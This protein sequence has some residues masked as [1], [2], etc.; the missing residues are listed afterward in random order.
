VF[1]DTAV[2][3]RHVGVVNNSLGTGATS[4]LGFNVTAGAKQIGTLTGTGSTA[5]LAGASLTTDHVRQAALAVE[6]TVTIR[7]N[8]GN[9]G[10]SR[11]ASLHVGAAGKLDLADN[12]LIYEYDGVSPESAVRSLVVSGRTSGF[13][14]LST[15]GDPDDDKVLAVADNAAW[16]KSEFGGQSI[17]TSTVIGKYTYFGDANLDGK[18]T[19]DD[20]LNVDANLGTGDSWLEGDFNMSGVTTG[21]DYLAIDAN[22]GKGTADPLAFVELKE[23]MVALHAEM[24]GEAYLAKLAQ[25]EAEGFSNFVPEPSAVGVVGVAAVTMLGRRRRRR[26]ESLT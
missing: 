3:T 15:P 24:F 17:D 23:E 21:D 12:D 11:V 22:L 8:G 25:V 20:Y 14:I 7:A 9:A 26:N 4:D 19:G 10:V 18:V 2:P 6:G 1:T 5:V 13:G 16:G